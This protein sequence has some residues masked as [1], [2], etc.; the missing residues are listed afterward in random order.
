MPADAPVEPPT[1]TNVTTPAPPV[2]T[3]PQPPPEP[4]VTVSFAIA[5]VVGSEAPTLTITV[6]NPS[7]QAVP[8]TRFDDPG[9]FVRHYLGLRIVRPDGTP[10]PLA[11]CAI[12]DWP[13][14]EEP[15]AAGGELLL[16]VPLAPLATRWPRGCYRFELAWDPTELARQL[17]EAAAVQSSQTSLNTEFFAIVRPLATVRVTR[18]QTVKLPGGASLQLV[19]HGHKRVMAGDTSPLIIR[20]TFTRPGKP[21]EGFGHS[22]QMESTRLFWLD[23]IYAF[24]LVDYAYDDWMELRYFGAVAPRR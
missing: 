21:P 10:Q 3:P 16:R 17:G 1:T 20:G 11:G 12:L 23:D 7:A 4:G 6:R 9:C 15:L 22:L 14:R 19:G 18:G 2:E 13:G 8:M 5:P 24:E